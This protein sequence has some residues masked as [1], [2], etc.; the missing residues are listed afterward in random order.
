VKEFVMQDHVRQFIEKLSREEQIELVHT[1]VTRWAEG[2]Q[3]ET[4]F[5]DPNG[6]VVGYFVPYAKWAKEH[7]RPFNPGYATEE[8]ATEAA[9]N[10][11]SLSEVIARLEAAEA[12]ATPK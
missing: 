1:L 8:E 12:A 11:P 9:R 6:V 7:P 4:T 2:Q 10:G 5:L 3:D